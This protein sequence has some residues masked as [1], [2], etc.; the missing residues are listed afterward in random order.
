MLWMS[1]SQP[2]LRPLTITYTSL[3][4]GHYPN[5]I[6]IQ[7]VAEVEVPDYAKSFCHYLP[8]TP[9][10]EFV[11]GWVLK[12]LQPAALEL[13]LETSEYLEKEREE[14]DGLWRKRL[15]RASY[16]ADRDGRHYRLIEPENR[17]VARQ[18][19]AFC[20]SSPGHSRRP[21]AKA[22]ATWRATYPRCGTLR[23]RLPPSARG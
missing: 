12:A 8:G 14:L 22:S 4:E 5:A 3:R 7:P 9:I 17:L 11:G 15:E 21:S 16:E 18:P 6:G 10:D 1:P 23:I 19:G 20:A 2:F 13:S